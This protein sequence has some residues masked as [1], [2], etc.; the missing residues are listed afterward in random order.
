VPPFQIRNRIEEKNRKHWPPFWLQV[1]SLNPG[2]RYVGFVYP[3]GGSQDSYCLGISHA[4]DGSAVLDCFREGKPPFSPE[5]VTL[6]FAEV[7][8]SYHVFRVVGDRY[9]GEWPREQLRKHGIEYKASEF[10]KSDIYRELLAPLNSGRIELLDNDRIIAQLCG[11]ELRTAWG[12]K[13]N[14]DHTPNGHDDLVN[15]AAAGKMVL[16]MGQGSQFFRE[17]EE[18]IHRRQRR[19]HHHRRNARAH[20]RR[21]PQH[22]QQSRN[23]TTT[24]SSAGTR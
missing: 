3:S 4:P 2:V 23:R 18:S 12:G 19:P 13:D 20:R 17:L 14:A 6:E 16:A 11:L 7:L 21:Q 10:A 5:Q 15:A 9:A 1:P 8:K 22:V 24:N